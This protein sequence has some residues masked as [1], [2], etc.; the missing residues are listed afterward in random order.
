MLRRIEIAVKTGP[1]AK[2]T[3]RYV[4][5]TIAVSSTS[6]QFYLN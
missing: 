2:K 4:P 6:A 5:Y 1:K 3:D